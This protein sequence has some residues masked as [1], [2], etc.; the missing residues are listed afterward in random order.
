MF[1]LPPIWSIER[2]AQE[3]DLWPARVRIHTEFVLCEWYCLN[4]R[5]GSVLWEF[6]TIAGVNTI[7]GVY[8]NV[9]LCIRLD[10]G[11][12]AGKGACALD[13][14]RGTVLWSSPYRVAAMQGNRFVCTSGEIRDV[15]SGA[16]HGNIERV[17]D[18]APWSE[19]H[20][21]FTWVAAARPFKVVDRMQGYRSEHG[22]LF[23]INADGA[24]AW[25]YSPTRNGWHCGNPLNATLEAPP[26]IYWVATRELPYRHIDDKIIE[27]IPCRKFLLNLDVA[28]GTIA[29]ALDLG[30]WTGDLDLAV[31]ER[32][33]AIRFERRYVAYWEH[34][35]L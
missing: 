30:I 26:Y 13:L 17:T 23:R 2:P 10:P 15:R 25:H 31:D 27:Y 20:G 28:S 34:S 14:L 6:P 21:E 1:C 33:C 12:R 24:V 3:R 35:V 4:R 16:L 19:Y 7:A 11:R 29:H 18:R 22:D 5:D 32:G 9:V 8:K